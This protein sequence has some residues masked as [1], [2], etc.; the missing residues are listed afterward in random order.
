MVKEP[1]DGIYSAYMVATDQVYIFS[2]ML[3]INYFLLRYTAEMLFHH[4]TSNS[5]YV[6]D[7]GGGFSRQEGK[8]QAPE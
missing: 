6:G 5:I 1:E 3:T 8:K 7:L 2:F 4:I